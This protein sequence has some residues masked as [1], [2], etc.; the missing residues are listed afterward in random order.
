MDHFDMD[1]FRND[2]Q[3][4]PLQAAV[5]SELLRQLEDTD[6]THLVLDSE[7]GESRTVAMDTFIEGCRQR[8]RDLQRQIAR[9]N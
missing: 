8:S 3:L 1:D 6:A 7:G 9:R 2:P 5:V 4:V